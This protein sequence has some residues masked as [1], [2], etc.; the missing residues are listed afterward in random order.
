MG[1]NHCR[2]KADHLLIELAEI[3]HRLVMT[4]DKDFWQI[5]L[6]RKVPLE[7]SGVV[8]FRVFPAISRH[9]M[10]L[11]VH[12]QQSDIHWIQHV[13]VVTIR[14]VEMIATLRE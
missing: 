2:G 5:A 12:V 4:L 11:V 3:E 14:G 10:P 1:P 8:L 13:S 6:Q 9:L 7:H